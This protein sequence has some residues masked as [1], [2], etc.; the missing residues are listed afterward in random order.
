MCQQVLVARNMLSPPVCFSKNRKLLWDSGDCWNIPYY[1][2]NTGL[3]Y[4][5]MKASE[6]RGDQREVGDSQRGAL[7]KWNRLWPLFGS[8][9]R[10]FWGLNW[11][12]K[13]EGHLDSWKVYLFGNPMCTGKSNRKWMDLWPVIFPWMLIHNFQCVIC[14][15]GGWASTIE[16]EAKKQCI[17]QRLEEKS[18]HNVR[19]HQRMMM[20]RLSGYPRSQDMIREKLLKVPRHK[21]VCVWE[22]RKL[23]WHMQI[24]SCWQLLIY[25]YIYYTYGPQ[26]RWV[27]HVIAML[28]VWKSS[29]QW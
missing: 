10:F 1:I 6:V 17:S 21:A 23:T 9:W 24:E 22:K 20:M 5:H 4:W 26:N 12:S 18:C 13:I 2:G 15:G 27:V 3:H 25:I 7:K 19:C 28:H 11:S 14:L 8:A 16:I 29:Q